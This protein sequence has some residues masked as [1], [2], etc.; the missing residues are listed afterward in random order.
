MNIIIKHYITSLLLTLHITGRK[1]SNKFGINK[2]YK[3]IY[4]MNDIQ[5]T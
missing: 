4:N 5:D 2:V 3:I 1:E